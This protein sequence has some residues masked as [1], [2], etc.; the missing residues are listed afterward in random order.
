MIDPFNP[1]LMCMFA[2]ALTGSGVPPRHSADEIDIPVVFQI[3]SVH[4]AILKQES[5]F[6]A[7]PCLKKDTRIMFLD[8]NGTYLNNVSKWLDLYT[9]MEW[10]YTTNEDDM[11]AW[12]FSHLPIAADQFPEF[13]P[14]PHTPL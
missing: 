1:L 13:S 7:L 8:V 6:M 9:S 3:E 5:H 10:K 11:Y 14:T 2:L 4:F 12:F